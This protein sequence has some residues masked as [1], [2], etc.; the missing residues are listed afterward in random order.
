MRRLVLAIVT[1][2]PAAAQNAGSVGTFEGSTDVGNPAR[3]GAVRFDA[4]RDAYELTGGG[5]NMWD[6]ED[7]FRFVWKKLSGNVAITA[8]IHFPQP[9]AAGHRKAVL[10]LRQGLESGAAYVDAALHGS[11]LTALQYRETANDITRSVRFPVE[12]PAWVRL[13][14]Q[15]QWFILST[16]TDGKKFQESG[17]IQVR[18]KDPLYLGIGVCSHDPKTVETAVFSHV[19]IQALPKAAPKQ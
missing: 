4:Q 15:A 2:L 18:L 7:Q 3:Q 9:S 5:A 14:R 19:S 17:A 13:E 16:S 8:E 1:L 12:G 11:G 6:K 10:M